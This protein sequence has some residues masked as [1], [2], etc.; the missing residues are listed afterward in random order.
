MACSKVGDVPVTCFW[1]TSEKPEDMPQGAD[2]VAKRLAKQP[3]G[4][5]REKNSPGLP[6]CH[7]CCCAGFERFLRAR[8]PGMRVGVLGASGSCGPAPTMGWGRVEGWGG[9]GG[10]SEQQ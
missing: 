6:L 7:F 1:P 10:G 4:K 8:V 9:G 5:Q 2:L 3:V